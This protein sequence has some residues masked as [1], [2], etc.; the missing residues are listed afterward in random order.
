MRAIVASALLL[1][2][3][4]AASAQSVNRQYTLNWGGAFPGCTNCGGA[5]S[6]FACS[7][8]IGKWN[9]GIN[10][11]KFAGDVPSGYVLTGVTGTLLG[12]YNCLNVA[13]KSVVGLY[14]AGV[15]IDVQRLDGSNQCKCGTC[16]GPRTYTN[17]FF[18]TGWPGLSYTNQNQIQVDA[19]AEDPICL[20]SLTLNATFTK[21]SRKNYIL[22]LQANSTANFYSCGTAANICASNNFWASSGSNTEQKINIPFT[23]PVGASGRVI[24]VDAIVFGQW[25]NQ[26][27]YQPD[28]LLDNQIIGK[29]SNPGLWDQ[30]CK[31]CGGS[32][33]AFTPQPFQ[34][35][36]PNYVSGGSNV[37]TIR[38]YRGGS[39]T[40]QFAV[41]RVMLSFTYI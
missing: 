17:D 23:D 7:N 35:G 8:G 36:W 10:K 19:G 30:T 6:A 38:L 5:E 29:G 24:A 9:E 14:L 13:S 22:D 2:L 31:G 12:T 26:G 32:S 37:F 40:Y 34:F 39:Y 4:V 27:G 18:R 16:D 25:G 41:S 1:A 11:I 3:A 21:T 28:F 15:P 20:S 33:Y